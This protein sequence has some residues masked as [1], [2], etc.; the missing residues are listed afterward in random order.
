MKDRWSSHNRTRG[1]SW[2]SNKTIGKTILTLNSG[3]LIKEFCFHVVPKEF[4]LRTDE[5]IGRNLLSGLKINIDYGDRH[6][7][8]GLNK[9]PL[10]NPDVKVSPR[11]E[12]VVRIFVNESGEGLIEQQEILPG[13][14]ITNTVVKSV[15]NKV[16]VVLIKT[17]PIMK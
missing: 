10:T 11:T 17:L 15:Q 13:V 12:Q 3:N 2:S 4:K 9:I 5:L 8:I 1:Y 6:L 14:Y 7:R 16:H